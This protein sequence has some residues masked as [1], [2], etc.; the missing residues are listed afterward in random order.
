M[1]KTFT[2]LDLTYCAACAALMAVCSWI[3]IEVGPVPFTLQTFAVFLTLLL[4]GGKRGTMSILVYILLGAIGVP[5]FAGFSGSLS[6]LL[7]TTGGYIIGF[8][9]AGLIYW[10]VTALLGEK[11]V[12]QAAAMV[13]GNLVCY[14]IGTVWFVEVYSATNGAVGFAMVLSWCVVPY[15]V[16]D[17]VKLVLALALGKRLRKILWKC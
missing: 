5:V 17:A 13:L 15:I 14:A 9:A 4:L 6:A 1:K 16:P 12:V 11:L 7:G 2:A 8:L 10:L 3:S